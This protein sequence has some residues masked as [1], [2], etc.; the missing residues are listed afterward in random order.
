VSD[1]DGELAELAERLD[2]LTAAT[3]GAGDRS[4]LDAATVD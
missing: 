2:T 4:G 3:A 1:L